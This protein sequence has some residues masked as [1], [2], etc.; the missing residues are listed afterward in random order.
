MNAPTKTIEYPKKNDSWIWNWDA[1]MVVAKRA[2]L[3]PL[4]VALTSHVPPLGLYAYTVTLPK[5]LSA[6]GSPTATYPPSLETA[7]DLAPSVLK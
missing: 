6:E 3:F 2:F 4:R 7:T 5:L 1:P